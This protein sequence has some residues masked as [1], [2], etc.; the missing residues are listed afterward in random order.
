MWRR[1]DGKLENC[2][3][4]NQDYLFGSCDMTWMSSFKL[5]NHMDVGYDKISSCLSEAEE[6]LRA[7]CFTSTLDVELGYSDEMK[8]VTGALS[9]QATRGI[10]GRCFKEEIYVIRL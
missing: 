5:E 7:W 4:M 1:W 9:I 6:E 10:Q 2:W 3:R 8:L